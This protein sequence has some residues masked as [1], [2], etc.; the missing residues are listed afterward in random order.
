MPTMEQKPI[1]AKTIG[2]LRDA[3]DKIIQEHGPDFEWNGFDDESIYIYSKHDGPGESFE[4]RP[5]G[6]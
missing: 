6:V 3:L 5:R 2:E 1:T 4:I